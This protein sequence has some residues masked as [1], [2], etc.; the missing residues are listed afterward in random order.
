MSSRCPVIGQQKGHMGP[1]A[2][3]N[4]FH[5]FSCLPFKHEEEKK[6]PRFS[7]ELAWLHC[8]SWLVV[9]VVIISLGASVHCASVSGEVTNWTRRSDS[10]APESIAEA[11]GFSAGS[12]DS[13]SY[14]WEIYSPDIPAA[15]G[16]RRRQTFV[17]FFLSVFLF[18]HTTK[19]WNLCF[20]SRVPDGGEELKNVMKVW[21]PK[22]LFESHHFIFF[23][24]GNKD[25]WW[26]T[27]IRTLPAQVLLDTFLLFAAAN[28]FIFPFL[29]CPTSCHAW[30]PSG[31]SSRAP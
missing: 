19:C 4:I 26:I 2:L 8:R 16:R 28:C 31:W 30:R 11:G 7:K 24:T 9:A 22:S 14:I 27:L 15:R 23:G 12:I 1:K 25:A 6:V 5:L 10:A 3:Q 17:I 29:P 13:S 21:D 20:V 18:S